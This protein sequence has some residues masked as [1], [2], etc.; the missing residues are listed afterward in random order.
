MPIDLQPYGTSCLEEEDP[1]RQ[2]RPRL[3]LL[4][5]PPDV[6][7]LRIDWDRLT[8][9]KVLWF[10]IAICYML[11]IEQLANLRQGFLLFDVVRHCPPFSLQVGGIWEIPK[12]DILQSLVLYA[13]AFSSSLR[14]TNIISKKDSYQVPMWWHGSAW[15]KPLF[16]L[17]IALVQPKNQSFI[18]RLRHSRAYLRLNSSPLTWWPC[19]CWRVPTG[20]KVTQFI[21][22]MIYSRYWYLVLWDRHLII[23]YLVPDTSRFLVIAHCSPFIQHKWPI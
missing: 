11:W 5:T 4:G 8:R 13:V 21:S 7:S 22:S 2:L 17:R 18:Y 20:S 12:K 1:T 3:L 9:F 6:S 19:C 10:L 15:Q 16:F 23:I 14:S